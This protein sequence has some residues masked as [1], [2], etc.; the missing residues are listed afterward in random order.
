MSSQETLGR[1]KSS[2]CAAPRALGQLFILLQYQT[3][4]HRIKVMVRKAENLAKLSR[5]PGA[6]GMKSL[7]SFHPKQTYRT[8]DID[9][10]TNA[11]INTTTLVLPALCFKPLSHYLEPPQS[12]P[13][14][15]N[16]ISSPSLSHS[17]IPRRLLPW[18]SSLWDYRYWWASCHFLSLS[19]PYRSLRSHQPPSGWEG[20]Q[21][22]GDQ[23]GGRTQ[24]CVERSLSLWPACWWHH[25]AA[26][27]SGVHHHA[28]R[29]ESVVKN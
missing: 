19:R 23:R 14:P 4:A 27:C 16:P 3:L 20:D 29:N 25:S 13:R 26:S 10:D 2:L 1:R 6:A 12:S 9:S 7:F 11:G 18:L 17:H 21:Y 5:M 24:R 28:G 22:E 15:H 8:V